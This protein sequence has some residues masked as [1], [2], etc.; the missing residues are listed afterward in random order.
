MELTIEQKEGLIG[1]SVDTA[2]DELAVDMA[3]FF[4]ITD[5]F[6]AWRA[7]G[8]VQ[9]DA[10]GVITGWGTAEVP[11]P[12]ASSQESE[13]SDASMEPVSLSEPVLLESGITEIGV[14]FYVESACRLLDKYFECHVSPCYRFDVAFGLAAY[15][16]LRF[17]A[18]WQL[19]AEHEEGAALAGLLEVGVPL[20]ST[21]D[22]FVDDGVL[23]AV[24]VWGL[25]RVRQAP[26]L[27][28]LRDRRK[29]EEVS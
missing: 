14:D 11:V 20:D 15:F 9:V 22:C 18:G 13:E 17:P 12:V 7:D 3:D 29:R 21:G 5:T 8:T 23:R 4:E 25:P 1:I 27:R 19:S 6:D 26:T 24:D 10:S 16:D 28:L 2:A